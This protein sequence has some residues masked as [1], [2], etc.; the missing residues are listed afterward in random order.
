MFLEDT[1]PSGAYSRHAADRS[2]QL[3]KDRLKAFRNILDYM[4][5]ERFC[6]VIRCR[7][8]WWSLQIDAWID[9]DMRRRFQTTSLT[10]TGNGG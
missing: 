5:Q 2:L 8:T 1:L 7:G 10:R 3:L 9:F 6:M 4:H